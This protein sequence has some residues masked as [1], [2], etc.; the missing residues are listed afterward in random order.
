VIAAVVKG[1]YSPA[2]TNRD[3]LIADALKHVQRGRATKQTT[4]VRIVERVTRYRAGM[5]IPSST[6]GSAQ[7]QHKVLE[8]SPTAA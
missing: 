5:E 6:A 1:H 8:S 4:L 7:D 2:G 3:E